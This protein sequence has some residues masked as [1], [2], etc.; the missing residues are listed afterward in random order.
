MKSDIFPRA[1]SQSAVGSSTD[2]RCCTCD[3]QML[4]VLTPDGST[5]MGEMMSWHHLESMTIYPKYNS[6]SIDVYLLEEQSRQISPESDLKHSLRLFW[7]GHPQQ[8]QQQQQHE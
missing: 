5:F 7:R 6:V 8:E 3:Q 1:H 4:R 2:G